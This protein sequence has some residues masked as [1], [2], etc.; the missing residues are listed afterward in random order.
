MK[1]RN[2]SGIEIDAK[3]YTFLHERQD[4][5]DITSVSCQI[6]VAVLILNS[7]NRPRSLN[8]RISVV[9][10]TSITIIF[11]VILLYCGRL[12]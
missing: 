12:N 2:H 6:H 8:L 10:T 7:K 1:K 9:I 11:S 5:N 3:F 4:H